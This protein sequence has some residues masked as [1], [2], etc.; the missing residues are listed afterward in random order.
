MKCPYC[1]AEVKEDDKFCGDCGKQI[2][3]K[4]A[5]K[6]QLPRKEGFFSRPVPEEKVMTYFIVGMIY[7]MICPI[8]SL[9]LPLHVFGGVAIVLAFV[10]GG[11]AIVLGYVL[12]KNGPEE[13]RN[14]GMGLLLAGIV[15]IVIEMTL[16]GPFIW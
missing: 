8:A 1:G 13:K 5:K 14:Y 9:F 15:G 11:V 4:A 7:A 6:P 2:P 16:L 12:W 3:W 10:F